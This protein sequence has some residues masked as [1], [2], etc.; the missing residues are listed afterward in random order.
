VDFNDDGHRDIISGSYPGELY[1]FSGDGSGGFAAPEK[2]K[3]ADGAEIKIESASVVYAA[4]WEGDGDLDLVVGDIKGRIHLVPNGSGGAAHE[5]GKP[6][7]VE[8]AGASIQVSGGNSGPI[9]ADWDGD[10]RNDLLVGCGDGSVLFYRNLAE[11]GA[12]KLGKPEVLVGP[13]TWDGSAKADG[14]NPGGVR[15]KV[16]VADFNADGKLDLLVGDFTSRQIPKP[17]L[18]AEQAA[19]RVLLEKRQKVISEKQ[20]AA[21]TEVLAKLREELGIPKDTPY[22]KLTQEQQVTFSQRMAELFRTDGRLANLQKA[23]QKIYAE[24]ANYQG[25]HELAGNVWLY[26]RN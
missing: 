10:G 22:Q 9:V 5:F 19:R 11:D 14:A 24:L 17:E 2:L 4:D 15:A 1:L 20:R 13:A 25:K 3:Y 7:P 12:P 23:Q 26:L 16:A 18:T 6:I 8:A 21:S